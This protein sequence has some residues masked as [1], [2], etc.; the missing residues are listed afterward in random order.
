MVV[1]RSIYIDGMTAKTFLR[2]TLTLKKVGVRRHYRGYN[3]GITTHTSI[4]KNILNEQAN[5]YVALGTPL[6]KKA[7]ATA[8]Q[9][10]TDNALEMIFNEY[11]YLAKQTLPKSSNTNMPNLAKK[12]GTLLSSFLNGFIVKC[13]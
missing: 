2:I 9:L 10:T 3:I 7:K 12:I 11:S 13:W 6:N 8:S 1:A 4:Y 5:Y